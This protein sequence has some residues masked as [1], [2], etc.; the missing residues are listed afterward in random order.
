MNQTP[1]HQFREIRTAVS[2]KIRPI[3]H[4]EF[5]PFRIPLNSS[6]IFPNHVLPW[7]VGFLLFS[8]V[9]PAVFPDGPVRLPLPYSL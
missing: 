2:I 4:P 1:H 3:P 7:S 6:M 5:C 8:G 9:H